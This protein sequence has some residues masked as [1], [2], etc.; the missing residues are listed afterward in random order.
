LDAWD[1]RAVRSRESTYRAVLANLGIAPR[2]QAWA[3]ERVQAGLLRTLRD[4][5]GRWVLTHHEDAAS[6]LPMAGLIDGVL[7][8]AVV[9][10]SFIEKSSIDESGVRWIIDFKTSTHE[11]GGLAN[12]LE[13]EKERYR[14]QLERYARLMSKQESRPIRLGLYFPMLGEWLEWAAS[15]PLR[16][17]A[18]LFEL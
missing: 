7:C 11:G 8:E 6:E 13:Q 9:D 16:K 3:I 14:E 18:T 4:P 10:R 1:E 5:R 2:D 15:V 17:Q 12:F